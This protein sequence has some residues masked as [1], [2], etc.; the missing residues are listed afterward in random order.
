[1][2]KFAAAIINAR[3]KDY[4][5]HNEQELI[6]LVAA[7]EEGAFTSLLRHFWNKVY[8]QA[9]VYLKSATLAQEITQDVFLKVWTARTNLLGIN[10]FSSYLFIITRN[11]IISTLRKKGREQITPPD[12]LQEDGWIPD[13]QLQYKESYKLLLDGIEA[14]PP[15]RSQ[16]FKM[17][18][19]EGLTY[20]EI[21]ARLNISRNGVK[22]HI[23]KALLFL[24]TYVSTHAGV[25]LLILMSL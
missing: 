23:V 19:L 16:V 7:N 21:A 2:F 10:N 20:D 4:P 9:N 6:R 18:R 11:E 24:R 17:S 8:T 3:L 25:M 13:L 12:T 5:L 1:M 14:L 15:V 22:D